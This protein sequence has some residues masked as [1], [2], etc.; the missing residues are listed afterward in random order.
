M[1]VYPWHGGD[2][3]GAKPGG[4][5]DVACTEEPFAFAEDVW[6]SAEL[7]AIAGNVLQSWQVPGSIG[8]AGLTPCT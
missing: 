3:S 4:D 1:V 7:D 2:G 6:M 5:G 8:V